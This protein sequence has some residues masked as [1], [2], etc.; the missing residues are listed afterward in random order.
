[1]DRLYLGMDQ[2]TFDLHTEDGLTL[3]GSFYTQPSSTPKAVI[4]VIHGH[5][6]HRG[7]FEPMIEHWVENGIFAVAADMRGHGKSQGKRGHFPS[8][9]IVLN[10]IETLLM[11][12]RS[13]FLDTPIF[14]YGHS[15]GGNLVAN[16]L[17]KKNILELAGGIMS[18]A[19]LRLAFEPPKSKVKLGQMMLK[20]WPSITLPSKLD[21]NNLTRDPLANEAY[22]KDE[23]VHDMI[24]PSLFEI[25]RLGGI[26]ALEHAP[27]LAIPTLVMHGHEDPI[28][29]CKASAE[30]AKNAP[31]TTWQLWENAYHEPHNDL[32]KEQ[33][34]ALVKDWVISQINK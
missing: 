19:W 21:S 23:L 30:F 33:V 18:S 7:R 14:L 4:V 12:A 2:E 1:M 22:V 13:E 5:G 34:W 27:E 26:W 11:K 16:Y 20:I 6:E 8:Q 15:M 10:D 9:A 17:L 29:D 31:H 25:I 3:S 28:T 24:S 32:E